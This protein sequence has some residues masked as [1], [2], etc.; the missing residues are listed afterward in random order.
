[1][2]SERAA[3]AKRI[4]ANA[5]V[6]QIP[7]RR[8]PAKFLAQKREAGLH[9]PVLRSDNTAK[10]R[11]TIQIPHIL[12]VQPIRSILRQGK[13]QLLVNNSLTSASEKQNRAGD[14]TRQSDGLPLV[15][16]GMSEIF[17]CSPVWGCFG[18][19]L[20]IK[21]KIA[22]SNEPGDF[23]WDSRVNHPVK[24]SRIFTPDAPSHTLASD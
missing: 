24:P 6:T 18:K 13:W 4:T 11:S 9:R 2:G 7:V 5:A 16:M 19:M 22:K 8:G 12:P 21:E 1:M 17:T 14:L 23:L 20:K 15:R 3:S 10:N